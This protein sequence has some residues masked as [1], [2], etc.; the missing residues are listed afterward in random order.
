MTATT[1]C[2]HT[3]LLLVDLAELVVKRTIQIATVESTAEHHFCYSSSYCFNE[4]RRY[5]LALA[6]CCPRKM[7]GR[8]TRPVWNAP[9]NLGCSKS[10]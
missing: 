5:V 7:H 8:C 2:E 1:L 6:S 10:E 4:V 9:G 3:S